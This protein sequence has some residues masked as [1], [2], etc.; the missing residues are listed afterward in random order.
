MQKIT[1]W[2]D[3]DSAAH[4]IGLLN[5]DIQEEEILL[6]DAIDKMKRSASEKIARIIVEQ[7]PL[8]EAIEEYVKENQKDILQSPKKSKELVFCTVGFRDSPPEVKWMRGYSE[9][10]IAQTLIKKGF[11]QCVNIKYRIVK[12]AIKALE[13]SEEKLAQFGIRLKYVK[14]NFFLDINEQKIAEEK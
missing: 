10:S 6:N 9:E 11:E 7:E 4:R 14:N 5:R 8:E 13:I 12:N 3:V 2:N 1:N